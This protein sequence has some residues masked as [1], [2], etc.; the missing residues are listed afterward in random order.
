MAIS[1]E[2]SNPI[3]GPLEREHDL[4]VAP[5]E[6]VS[7]E[8]AGARWDVA[9][10]R[11]VLIILLLAGVL[12][13]WISQPVMPLL[14]I[15]AIV[16][17]L[18]SPI[19]D[20]CERL[21]IPRAVST[22][23]LFVLVL[24]GIVL[25]PVFLVPVI[26]EQLQVLSDFDVNGTAI[27]F[28][29]WVTESLNQLPDTIQLFGFA[30]PIGQAMQDVEQNF[31][32][33]VP[34][35]TEILGA[36]QQFLGTATTVVGSTALVGL[37]VVGS[38][39]QGFVMFI[40]TF[41][42]SLYLT[43]DAPTIR[44][45]VQ[46]LFPRVYQPEL[47]ELF[48]HISHIW[49]SF[50]RGQ[51]VLCFIIGIVTWLALESV[52]MPGALILGIIAGMLEVIPSLGPTLSMIP[53]VIVALIQGSDVLAV[54][55]ISNFG[56]ALIT[57]AIYFIIQQLENSIIVPRVIGSSVNL[58][59]IVVICGVAI[60]FNVAGIGGAFLAAPVIAS[61]RVLGGYLHAKLLDYPPF[62]GMR[63][64]P[65]RSRQP[66]IY[67][68]TLRGNEL[69]SSAANTRTTSPATRATHGTTDVSPAP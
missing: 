2:V 38:I 51:L 63:L 7:P 45:Y 10:K 25:L 49:Q 61:F 65:M 9:T 43:K 41:F 54:Y 62:Q 34:T 22:I 60:G 28:I 24:V 5:P 46:G 20:F 56:F 27:V 11:T 68:R 39:V 69:S 35:I 4:T 58:H 21:Y 64:P 23:V 3:H 8:L 19:V 40:I 17:Y 48:R 1:T 37:T 52:G 15:S 6:V 42:L 36:I 44:S 47:G 66:F 16:A 13:L 29:R 12:V 50:F 18:L 26:L 33:S 59:P 55:G 32:I 53:A 31:S 30:V 57:V 67:R 14:I